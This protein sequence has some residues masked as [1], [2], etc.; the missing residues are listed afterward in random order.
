M[1]IGL[2]FVQAEN[3]SSVVR[4]STDLGFMWVVIIGLKIEIDMISVWGS[5]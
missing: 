2:G 4:E 3:D 1:E 5:E